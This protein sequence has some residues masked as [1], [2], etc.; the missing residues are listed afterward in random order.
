MTVRRSRFFGRQPVDSVQADEDR[1]GSI[2]D[3][4]AFSAF[5]GPETD[6]KNH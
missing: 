1:S 5:P 2:G 6:V 4:S 3:E